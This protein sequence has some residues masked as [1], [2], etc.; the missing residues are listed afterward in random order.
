MCSNYLLY[1][2]LS[3]CILI[4]T[5]Y[6][7]NIEPYNHKR[8][9]FNTMTNKSLSTQLI[10]KEIHHVYVKLRCLCEINVSQYYYIAEDVEM[11]LEEGDGH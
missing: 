11:V 9:E 1:K 6:S 10:H 5:E 8:V 2:L 3:R 7:F 4:I